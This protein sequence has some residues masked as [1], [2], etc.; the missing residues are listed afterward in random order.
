MERSIRGF[1]NE[2]LAELR[3]GAEKLVVECGAVR[4]GEKVLIITD[5]GVDLSVA[6]SLMQAS[7]AVGAEATVVTMNVR[8]IPGDEPPP[9]VAQAM[10]V[11]DVI[12]Q[13]TSTIMFYT[14][15][16]EEACKKGARFLGMTGITPEVLAGPVLTETDFREQRLVLEKLTRRLTEARKARITTPGGTDLVLSLEGRMAVANPGFVTAP[17]EIS[18]T[19]NIESYIAPIEDSINGIA[20][21]DG[22]ISISGLVDSPVKIRIEGGLAREIEGGKDAQNLRKKLEALDNPSVYQVAELGI[23]LNPGGQIRGAIIEDEG[24]L[25]TCHIALGDNHRFGGTSHAPVHIDMVQRDPTIELDE[26]VVLK[27]REI[28]L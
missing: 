12:Y 3:R 24:A 6:Y 21:I 4:P 11:S 20:I 9:Q 28:Y 15:A 1:S 25:G 10:L 8:A 26:E 19:P 22:T 18:G 17:G 2:L 23:G 7:L 5:P 27:G 14:Q 16:K 13:V